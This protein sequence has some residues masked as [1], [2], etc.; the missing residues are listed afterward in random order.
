[1]YTPL[2]NVKV[3]QLQS[4]LVEKKH[5]YDQMITDNKEFDEVKAVFIEIKVL[6]E[7]IQKAQAKKN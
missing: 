6:E 5:Q 1:M 4:L 7:S 2:N 3:E